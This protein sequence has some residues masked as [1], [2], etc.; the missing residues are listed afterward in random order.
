[1]SSFTAAAAAAG[2]ELTL[3]GV[4]QSVVLTRLASSTAAAMPPRETIRAFAA[5]GATMA[6]FLSV[7][8]VE[9]LVDELLADGTGFDPTTTVIIAHRV[10]QP[11]ERII[12][13]TIA[14]L[15]ATVRSEQLR[16]ATLF[17]IGPAL[18]GTLNSPPPGTRR[19]HVYDPGYAT[20]FRPATST[21]AH[22][23]Q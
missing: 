10:S 14:E 20:R 19:S 18:A 17:L 4:A 5:T 9:H 3:P 22:D 8:H 1:V 12:S 13:T 23:R 7:S 6:V 21:A 15:A 11:D 2:C 16:S